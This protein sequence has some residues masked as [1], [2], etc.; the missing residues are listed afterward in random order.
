MYEGDS[1]YTLTVWGQVGLVIVSIAFALAALTITRIM[2]VLRP[3]LLRPPIWFVLFIC[4]VWASP[5]GYYAY[6]RLVIDGL[7]AQ[8]VIDA[9]PRPEVLVALLTFRGPATLSA[10]S[11][12]L[13][14]WAMLVV[15]LLPRRKKCRD[16]AN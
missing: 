6:Y 9:P 1:F 8:S 15:A 10:H 14:G 7:P 11:V 16:A 3:L 2:T 4:F 13:L 12:G 5:Q